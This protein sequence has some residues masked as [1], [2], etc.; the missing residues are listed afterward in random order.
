MIV[1]NIG[2]PIRFNIMSPIRILGPYT[3]ILFNVLG[4]L[5]INGRILE[6]SNGFNGKRLKTAKTIFIWMKIS[7]GKITSSLNWK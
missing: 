5:T 2:I 7:K 6:P 4:F 3:S 1:D